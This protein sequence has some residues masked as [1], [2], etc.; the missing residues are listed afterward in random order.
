[1][2]GIPS[3]TPLGK[4]VPVLNSQGN[5]F[6]WAVGVLILRLLRIQLVVDCSVDVMESPI[7]D[8]GGE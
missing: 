4:D 3:P 1:M 2:D 5:V 6:D 7:L 8:N